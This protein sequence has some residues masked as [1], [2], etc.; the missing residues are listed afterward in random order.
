MFELGMTNLLSKGYTLTTSTNELGRL[1]R[2]A[3][4][5]GITTKDSNKY[6]YGDYI[7]QQR[8]NTAALADIDLSTTAA[9]TT[10]IVEA[11]DVNTFIKSASSSNYTCDT[12]AKELKQT[13]AE[14]QAVVISNNY[15]VAASGYVALKS[16]VTLGAGTVDYF[17]SRDGGTTFTQVYPDRGVEIFNQPAG[18]DFCFKLVIKGGAVVSAIGFSLR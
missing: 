16:T 10:K 15:T 11:M 13:D 18:T 6:V 17:V 1:K 14:T 4:V 12:T 2:S 8:L 9:T 7:A 3:R 5:L